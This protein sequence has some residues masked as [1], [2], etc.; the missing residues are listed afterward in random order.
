MGVK[1][2]IRRIGGVAASLVLAVGLPAC[3]S[4]GDGSGYPLFTNRN[5]NKTYTVARPTYEP[6]TGKPFFL[7]GYA[8]ANYGAIFPRRFMDVEQ[9][10]PAPSQ[11]KVSVEQGAWD[12]E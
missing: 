11:P 2:G 5:P 4:W 12:P 7:G 8:G 9:V 6:D 1:R 10:V 3:A